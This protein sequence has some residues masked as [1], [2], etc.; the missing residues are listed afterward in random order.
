MHIKLGLV[1]GLAVAA[2]A[3]SFNNQF[4]GQ[5]EQHQQVGKVFEHEY[6]QPNVE[7]VCFTVRP[8]ASCDDQHVAAYVK[9]QKVGLHCVNKHNPIAKQ[10]Q[11]DADQGQSLPLE[12]KSQDL[13]AYVEVPVRCQRVNTEEKRLRKET[14]KTAEQKIH[15]VQQQ[16]G[17]EESFLFEHK[18]WTNQL[19]QDEQKQGLEH[20]QS[21][22][23]RKSQQ[24][25]KHQLRQHQGE[26]SDDEDSVQETEL[27]TMQ[28]YDQLINKQTTMHRILKMTDEQFDRYMEHLKFIAHQNRRSDKWQQ[29]L[30]QVLP[31][32]FSKVAKQFFETTLEQQTQTQAEKEE[33]YEQYKEAVKRVYAYAVKQTLQMKQLNQITGKINGERAQQ[34]QYITNQVARNLWYKIQKELTPRQVEEVRKIAEQVQHQKPQLD[35]MI[36][37][38]TLVALNKQEMK[39][40]EKD[41]T[42]VL[43]AGL[44]MIHHNQKQNQVEGDEYKRFHGQDYETTFESQY[45]KLHQKLATIENVQQWGTN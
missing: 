38:E 37:D 42:K 17:D 35:R 43:T 16:D 12:N 32:V 29:Q 18:P 11:R 20:E 45:P 23:V 3:T 44:K 4:N 28:Q 1:A 7:E 5:Q 14:E 9:H 19:E 40:L 27:D 39:Q 6:I 22:L 21:Q 24:H 36:A 25:H 31:N 30:D 2:S 13:Q 41:L 26:D 15:I 10:F 8:V 33:L 34:Q